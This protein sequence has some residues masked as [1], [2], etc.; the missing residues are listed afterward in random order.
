[1]QPAKQQVMSSYVPIPFEALA[2]A[3]AM[4]Q[5]RYE[6]SIQAEQG[7]ENLLGAAKGISSVNTVSQGN[8]DA[9]GQERVDKEVDRFRGMIGK[10]QEGNPDFTSME[11]MTGMRSTYNELKRSMSSGV[12]GKEA[13]SYAALQEI[14]KQRSKNKDVNIDNSLALESD[15]QLLD[16][17]GYGVDETP[18]GLSQNVSFGEYVDLNK[19]MNVVLKDIKETLGREGFSGSGLEAYTKWTKEK[20]VST[21]RVL[22]V[23]SERM[24]DP[25]VQNTIMKRA[26]WA[27]FKEGDTS[28]ENLKKHTDKIT[29]GLLKNATSTFVRSSDITRFLKTGGTSGSS[30]KKLAA[31]LSRGVTLG[32]E[33]WGD[34]SI[35]SSATKLNKFEDDLNSIRSSKQDKI[36]EY[37][38]DPDTNIDA[39]GMD[40]TRLMDYYDLQENSIKAAHTKLYDNIKEGMR[41]AGFSKNDIK[42]FDDLLS[43]TSDYSKLA[44]KTGD[45][46]VA[47]R[48]SVTGEPKSFAED[49]FIK[50][51]NNQYG[52]SFTSFDQAKNHKVK[53]GGTMSNIENKLFSV[54]NWV[55]NSNYQK[56][57]KKKYGDRGIKLNINNIDKSLK[58][59]DMLKLDSFNQSFQ[60]SIE[61]IKDATTGESWGSEDY[62]NFDP[63]GATLMGWS[64]D[65]NTGGPTLIYSVPSRKGEDVD[66]KIVKVEPPQGF[67][68]V[69]S[70]SG[71]VGYMDNIINSQVMNVATGIQS[72]NAQKE[73]VTVSLG[74]KQISE[75]NTKTLSTLQ[76]VYNI[77]NKEDLNLDIKILSDVQTGIPGEWHVLV[78]YID[79][80]GKKQTKVQP[81]Y[82]LGGASKIA[83]DAYALYLNT[84][85]KK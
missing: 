45:E 63:K 77:D 38:I 83:Q 42:E 84:L 27:A 26:Q 56:Y 55:D 58:Q 31:N 24:Q 11:Y 8:V 57:M 46:Y 49:E 22:Q 34:Y 3:G 66:G 53:V 62:T 6:Q 33:G 41:V 44:G 20:G 69:L 43:G 54:K 52:T 17:A 73:G 25:R 76:K 60:N 65:P 50:V 78:P 67:E 19:E 70:A 71:Q 14:Y 80:N 16:Y 21:D 23:A 72:D 35:S 39:Q 9:H 37:G 59:L 2:Q 15:M 36:K 1:M 61:D 7:I 85:K 47:Q 82:G 13:A 30:A 4:T 18:M 12:L 75:F 79:A 32:V 68:S 28:R 74:Y 81:T 51:I 10:L 64:Y 40:R 5:Q 29:E 48:S